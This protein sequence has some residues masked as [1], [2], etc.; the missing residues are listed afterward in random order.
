MLRIIHH[1]AARSKV[2]PQIIHQGAALGQVTRAVTHQGAAETVVTRVVTHQ[3]AAESA[4]T[5]AVIRRCWRCLLPCQRQAES[6]QGR[7]SM[8]F[9]PLLDRLIPLLEHNTHKHYS[10]QYSILPSSIL[11]SASPPS[12]TCPARYLMCAANLFKD[13]A[14]YARTGDVGDLG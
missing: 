3:A 6:A 7:L 10:A 4:V 5:G 8:A 11:T 2:I 9:L 13:H 12:M 1:R 14:N